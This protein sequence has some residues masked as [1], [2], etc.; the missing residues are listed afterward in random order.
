MESHK[1]GDA[2]EARVV[3]ELKQRGIPVSIPFGDNERYD[4]IAAAPHGGL[5]RIQVKTGWLDDGV[6]E[7]HGK[8]QHTNSAGNTYT[9]YD[10]DVEYFLVFV[11]ELESLYLIAESEFQTSM[12][13]RVEEPN[14]VH[15][16]IN[17]AEE[18]EFDERWPP[19]PNDNT[20]SGDPPA[21][22]QAISLL[23]EKNLDVSRAI[24]TDAYDLLVDEADSCVRLAVEPGWVRNGRI[25]FQPSS[26]V[27]RDR[28]DWF[29]VYCDELDETYL[30]SPDEFDTSISL[31]IAETQRSSPSSNWADEYEFDERWPLPPTQEP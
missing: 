7:F 16:T 18:F 17:W 14:Q 21:V 20:I 10:G 8:S 15:K 23:R 30:I 27:D 26:A 3:A 22:R 6:I 1:K 9:T 28:I 2:T 19:A 31:R 24:T 25:R 11:P 4:V 5:L 29:L 12:R 13:L